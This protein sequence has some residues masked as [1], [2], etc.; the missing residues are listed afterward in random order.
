MHMKQVYIIKPIIIHFFLLSHPE[1]TSWHPAEKHFQNTV[2]I[3][4]IVE[5]SWL[6]HSEHFV[7]SQ[8][9]EAF[10]C[11]L[12]CDAFISQPDLGIILQ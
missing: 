12:P 8:L 11:V 1:N 2:V 9:A 6:Y 7:A 5:V 3:S 10:D 4:K